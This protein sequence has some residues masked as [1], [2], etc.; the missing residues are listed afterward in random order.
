MST[1]KRTPGAVQF[2][3]QTRESKAPFVFSVADSPEVTIYEPDAGTMMALTK[4]GSDPELTLQLLLGSEWPKIKQ[5]LE[6]L[7]NEVIIEMLRTIGDYFDLAEYYSPPAAANRAER[8]RR[9][10]R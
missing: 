6:P 10:G 9:S 1:A 2:G 7:H 5:H 8:R 3:V 4:A